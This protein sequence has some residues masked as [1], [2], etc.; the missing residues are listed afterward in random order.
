MTIPKR[1]RTDL[2]EKKAN[3]VQGRDG[4]RHRKN[5]NSKIS[6]KSK[7]EFHIYNGNFSRT[8]IIIFYLRR[9]MYKTFQ[10]QQ[11]FKIKFDM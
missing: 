4:N 10:K 3:E 9:Q 11:Y 5:K 6:L 2:K 8:N 7:K 1:K